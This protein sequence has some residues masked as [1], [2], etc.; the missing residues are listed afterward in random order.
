MQQGQSAMTDAVHKFSDW[1][2]WLSILVGILSWCGVHISQ[3]AQVTSFILGAILIFK[4]ARE[5]LRGDW[6]K[7]G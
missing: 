4:N 6:D 1:G 5:Y 3:L 2:A 7:K